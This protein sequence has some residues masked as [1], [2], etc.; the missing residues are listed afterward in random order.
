MRWNEL[1]D[2]GG[3][4]LCDAL[5]NNSSLISCLAIGNGLSVEVLQ[6]IGN[7]PT[8]CVFESVIDSIAQPLDL[9]DLTS[10]NAKMFETATKPFT[11]IEEYKPLDD[12]K[13]LVLKNNRLEDGIDAVQEHLR[14]ISNQSGD[15][16]KKLSNQVN[17]LKDENSKLRID[18]DEANIRSERLV[19]VSR[20]SAA[21]LLPAQW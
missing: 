5:E 4:A 15:Q 16:Q 11:K 13:N 9:E 8:E 10:R 19:E 21:C 2:V 1:G 20:E 14:H 18:L 6:K 3:Q 7:E 17:K 12:T